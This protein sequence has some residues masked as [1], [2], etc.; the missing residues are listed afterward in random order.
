MNW[1]GVAT[2]GVIGFIVGFLI[3]LSANYR[4]VVVAGVVGAASLLGGFGFMTLAQ[5]TGSDCAK[6]ATQPEPAPTTPGTLPSPQS[7]LARTDGE[8]CETGLSFGAFGVGG[9]AGIAV[10]WQVSGGLNSP[11]RRSPS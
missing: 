11:R 5:P 2:A 9:W 7:Y 3:G 1:T 6:Y 8:Q 10:G 4:T